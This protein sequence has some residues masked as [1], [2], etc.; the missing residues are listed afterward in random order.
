[1]IQFINTLIG[2]RLVFGVSLLRDFH[3]IVNK[4]LV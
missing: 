3:K 2:V 1:M 4:Y